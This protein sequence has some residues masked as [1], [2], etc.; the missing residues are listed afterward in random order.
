MHVAVPWAG[1]LPGIPYGV[2]MAEVSGVR[3]TSTRLA[4]HT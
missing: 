3:K 2:I 4:W 1:V